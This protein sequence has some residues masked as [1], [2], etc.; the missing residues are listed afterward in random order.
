MAAMVLSGVITPSSPPWAV[1]VFASVVGVGTGG[2]VVMI[3]AIFPDIPDVDELA[4]GERREGTY[5][6]LVTFIRKFSSA[7]AIFLVSNA[8]SVA[9]YVP[10]VEQM[11]EGKARLVEQAQSD[12]FI[13]VLRAV[14]A[15]APIALLALA[16]VFA[17]R[18]PLTPAVH[19]RLN[20]LLAARRAGEPESAAMAA[21]AEHLKAKLIG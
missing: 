19:A 14:F 3:Y 21:E 20:R 15:G 7:V 1:Y 8:L 17:L 12:A 2:I 16:L 18:Y 4:T 11:V 9:G 13:G 6:A 5:A 10:P